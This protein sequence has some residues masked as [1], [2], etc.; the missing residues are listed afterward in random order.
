MVRMATKGCKSRALSDGGI[1]RAKR[2]RGAL[3]AAAVART[4]AEKFATFDKT[5]GMAA[6]EIKSRASLCRGTGGGAFYRV[7]AFCV[8]P[9]T[10]VLLRPEC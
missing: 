7:L 10:T 8:C 3:A 1:Y 4:V 6:R 5:G 2:W 9:V